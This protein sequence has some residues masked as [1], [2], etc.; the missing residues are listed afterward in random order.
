MQRTPVTE[1][2]S[3]RRWHGA[4]VAG[5]SR[6]ESLF[7]RSTPDHLGG[8]AS[9]SITYRM[10]NM[11]PRANTAGSSFKRIEVLCDVLL[12]DPST[13]MELGTDHCQ[14]SWVPLAK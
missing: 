12:F 2:E 11:T 1:V 3:S 5:L 4:S 6:S 8:S 10:L 14:G 9:V 13:D 7:R